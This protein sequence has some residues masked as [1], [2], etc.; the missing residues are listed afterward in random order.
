VNSSR[1]VVW[2]AGVKAAD[3]M[4]DLGGLETNSLNQLVVGSTLQTTRDENVFAMGDCAA[5][6]WAGR[7]GN[8]PPRAQAAHQQASHLARQ[9]QRRLAGRALE[10]W[11]YRDFGSLVSLGEQKT[12]GNL[13][14][15][16]VGGSLWVD[17]LFA[18][19]MY[20]SLYKMHEIAVHGYAK[21]ALGTASRL[22]TRSTKP[23]V[24]L[25]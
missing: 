10:S 3:S 5:A 19:G 18:R 13:M 11:K 1:L 7:G 16:L 15:S 8:V 20:L 14:G 9:L 22:L 12:V 21:T 25:H 23:R 2:A 4:R 24:K 6:P 17:G